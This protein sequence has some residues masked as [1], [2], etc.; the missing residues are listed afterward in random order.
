[1]K[2]LIKV[3]TVITLLIMMQGCAVYPGGGIGFESYGPMYGYSYGHH[4]NPSF[5]GSVRRGFGRFG[6]R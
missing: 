4:F 6:Y 5:G 2:T 1:M 3:L